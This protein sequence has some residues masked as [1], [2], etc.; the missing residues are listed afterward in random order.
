MPRTTVWQSLKKR[1]DYAVPWRPV[2]L[3]HDHIP[4]SK[5]SFPVSK[6]LQQTFETLAKSR[7]RAAVPTLIAALQSSDRAIHDGAIKAML[8]RRSKAGHLAVL[9]R[10]HTL[11]PEQRELLKEG[12]GRINSALRDAVVSEDAQLFANG[13]EIIEQFTEIDLV[14]ALITVAE[15]QKS[16]HAEKATQ[17]IIRL[18]DQLSDLLQGPRNYE[19]RRDPNVMKRNALESLE[20]SVD[21]FRQHKRPQLVEAFVVL[22]GTSS[23]LLRSILETPHHACFS[24][25]LNV[26]TTSS[27]PGVLQLLINFLQRSDVP[28]VVIQVISRRADEPFADHLLAQVEDGISPK[29]QK[30]LKRIQSFV[31]LNSRVADPSSRTDIEQQCVVK[32]ASASGMR[33]EALLDFLE[34]ML[35]GGTDA[36]RLAACEALVPLQ[37]DR[38]DRLVYE[39]LH[40]DDPCVQA[41]AT[42]QLRDRHIPGSMAKL[43]ELLDSDHEA[44]RDAAREALS[45]FS[46]ENYLARFETLS[47]EVRCSTGSLVSK[48]DL[49][50]VPLLLDE[51]RSPA[52]TR[53][54]R[55]IEMAVVMGLISRISGALIER[56]QDED[57]LVRT[58]VADALHSCPQP[59]VQAALQ[60]ALHDRSS[61]VQV[62]ARNS[63]DAIAQLAG[64]PHREMPTETW[65]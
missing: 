29:M 5:S 16:P 45:E 18:I 43:L 60:E 61:A 3:F 1:D 50:T 26:I 51:L 20:R 13:C 59:A 65:G 22:A 25:V 28:R 44:V 6:A 62:A 37:G 54:L 15:N 39:A 35:K 8:K 19:D 17:I 30:N 47:D 55:A 7:N 34:R 36:G 58:S 64:E 31:W 23:G 52:R 21:R 49:E 4:G 10:W 14:S 32:L 48:V 11:A 63:L 41:E 38:P 40:D 42:R 46:F 56:L 2:Q 53:R 27:S 24:V 57:H 12:R 9:Q 33:R